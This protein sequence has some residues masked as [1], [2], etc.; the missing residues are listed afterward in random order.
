MD[1][2]R[3]GIIQEEEGRSKFL[4]LIINNRAFSLLL[5]IIAVSILMSAFFPESFFSYTNLSS[6]LLAL[7][8]EGS[9]AVGMM[10]LIVGGVFDIS[11]GSN[12]AVGGAV[13]AFLIR[14]A[15]VPIPIG[16][17]AGIVACMAAGAANGIIVTKV[18]V[19]PLITTL[20][21]LGI[22][23]G[24]AVLIAGPGIAALPPKFTILGQKMI[25]G[26]QIPSYYLFA[27]TIIGTFLLSKTRYF[28]QLYYIGG[29]PKA[30]ALSGIKVA[31]TLT[32]NFIIMGVIA[33]ITGV[34]LAARLN[35]AIGLVGA[36]VELRVLTGVIIGGG[37]LSGGKGTIPGAFMGALFMGFIYNVMVIAG[38]NVYYQ[39]IV[40]G[41]IL[42]SAVSLDV[43]LLK[44]FQ[45]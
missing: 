18:G 10:L 34:I 7:S 9:L 44:K 42:L 1:E 21:M 40:I 38:V 2:N 4:N 41:I 3:T 26:L 33:G 29:N 45:I 39:S 27:I 31:K 30:A 17:I 13:T 8:I 6:I 12:L 19:N 36:G 14:R 20:A 28:R 24:I 43:I 5:L 35:S 37:S 16:M 23:R 22:L 32:V 15:G 11:I 25:L